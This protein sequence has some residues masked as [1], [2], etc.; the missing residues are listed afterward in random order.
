VNLGSYLLLSMR[1]VEPELLCTLNQLYSEHDDSV[2]RQCVPFLS[3]SCRRAGRAM[4]V[5]IAVLA[6]C[7]FT[8]APSVSHSHALITCWKTEY[9]SDVTV[10]TADHSGRAV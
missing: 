2:L 8:P 1:A 9:F 6:L 4:C 10:N 3:Q 5:A 7:H